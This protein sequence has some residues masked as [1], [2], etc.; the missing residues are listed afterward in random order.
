MNFRK[1]V[2]ILTLFSLLTF[3][4]FV[5]AKGYIDKY[6]VSI[7]YQDEYNLN[8]RKILEQEGL[9]ILNEKIDTIFQDES[10][11]S[12]S[13][14]KITKFSSNLDFTETN[15][16]TSE[17]INFNDLLNINR[18][19]LNYTLNIKPAR[20]TNT[21]FYPLLDGVSEEINNFSFTINLNNEMPRDIKFYLN[22]KVLSEDSITYNIKDNVITGKYNYKLDVYDSLSFTLEEKES[23]NI[24]F[25]TKLS[26][27]VPIIGA[28][29]SYLLWF[30]FGKDNLSKIKKTSRPPRTINILETSL[31]YNNEVTKEDIPL[32]VFEL[33]NKGYIKITETSNSLKITKLKEY[34]GKKYNEALF[35]KSIF[36]KPQSSSL[37]NY[38]S[39]ME[40]NTKKV[41]N[42]YLNEVDIKNVNMLKTVEELTKRANE[43]EIKRKF[44]ESNTASKKIYISFMSAISLILVTCNPFLETGKL[45][46]VCISALFSII[47]LILITKIVDK[48][49]FEKVSLSQFIIFIGIVISI[50]LVMLIPAIE[51]NKIYI[52]AYIIGVICTILMLILYKYMPKRTKNGT[53]LLGQIESFQLFLEDST[54]DEIDRVLELDNQY[55]YYIL[56]YTYVLKN[57]TKMKNKFKNVV[58][59]QPTWYECKKD[60]NLTRF[61]KEMDLLLEYLSKDNES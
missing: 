25:L 28:F 6:N 7:N 9:E 23:I 36:K 14:I 51:A 17:I 31:I 29:I 43:D 61:C 4:V 12:D 44:F 33:A 5:N 46:L 40:E 1:K 41:K 8:V 18:I 30:C 32:M 13:K 37:K 49:N 19:T 21:I 16:D 50:W 38:I 10:L 24:S 48:V 15:N 35:F 53:K 26:I 2:M 11:N 34:D 39:Y 45:Y 52:I 59:V 57:T 42:V 22:D 47:S 3:P 56:P 54:T 20:N 60:F 55:F 27:V 58:K